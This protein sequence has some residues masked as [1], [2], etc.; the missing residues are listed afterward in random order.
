MSECA[1]LLLLL[2]MWISA[3]AFMKMYCCCAMQAGG[4]GGGGIMN[5]RAAEG[6]G[7]ERRRNGRE[8][9]HHNRHRRGI[10]RQLGNGIVKVRECT[11]IFS[12]VFFGHAYFDSFF[13]YR[14]VDLW[15]VNVPQ[16]LLYIIPSA[17]NGNDSRF[18]F[19]AYSIS[20][21]WSVMQM[22]LRK[23]TSKPS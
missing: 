1:A 18:Q 9:G 7:A 15:C 3:M 2:S 20:L 23:Q 21:L 12:A 8:A 17:W 5:P 16:V 22:L 13:S 10:P 14:V 19:S 11:G 6:W 4:Q